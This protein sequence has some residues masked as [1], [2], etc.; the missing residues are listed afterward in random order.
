MATP[1]TRRRFMK[2]AAGAAVTILAGP[3]LARTYAANEKLNTAIIG[4]GGRGGAHHGAAGGENLVALCDID[5]LRLA[6]CAKKF[7]RAKTY[8]DY[9]VLYDQHKDLDAVF[10]ATPDHSHYPASMMA[11]Q[12]DINVLTEKPLTH[13]VWEA[14]ALAEAAKKHGVATQMGNQS[15]AGE[16]I[17]LAC[18]FIRDGAIGPVREVHCWTDRPIW[19]QGAGQ[20]VEPAPVPAYVHWDEWLGP[21]PERPYAE[22]VGRDGKRFPT[23]H[24]FRWRGFW[25]FG[26]GALGDMACHVMDAA[27]WSMRLGSPTS[28]EAESSGATLD[29][30]PNWSIVR[31]E[32][33]ARGEM[34]PCTLTWY[35]GGKMPPRPEELEAGREL[36]GG[37]GG[38]MWVGEK[39]KMIMQ[40]RGGPRLIPESAM[41]AYERPEKSIPRSAGYHQEFLGACKGGPAAGANF[42][43]YAG[44][45]VETIIL[46]TVAIRAGEKLTWDAA[47][48]KVTNCPKADRLI[49]REYR[50]GWDV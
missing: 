43:D 38:T 37:E 45:F 2:Q 5:D 29:T 6:E 26:T 22:S 44:P 16:G 47:N 42:V 15:H 49:R 4:C 8:T 24:P 10:V 11:I 46:G 41:Q 40:C 48:L 12:R 30:G 21:A 23:Y 19:P 13:S 9:R 27:Y 35:D 28:V 31:Y 20:K 39:G 33:A 1:V 25:D 14:R 3:H 34:P 50:K 17:R 7:P 32:F 36:P 18:E